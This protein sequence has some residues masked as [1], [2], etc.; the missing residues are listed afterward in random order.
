M[1][2]SNNSSTKR[3][4]KP[5][6][7]FRFA[8]VISII[9]IGFNLAACQ[10]EVGTGAPTSVPGATEN[11]TD[12]DT[13]TA[14]S[15]D[16]PTQPPVPDDTDTIETKWSSSG[17]SN[18]FVVT[19]E[20]KN[21]TCARCH[22]PENWIPT[23]EDMPESCS[24]CKFEIDPPPPY[25]SETD[26]ANIECNVCHKVKRKEVQPEYVWLEIAPIEE[27][28][29]VA[30]TTELCDK[31]HLAGDIQNHNSVIVEGDHPGYHCTDCHDAH[32]NTASCSASG[33]HEN[34]FETAV[35]IVGHDDNH[36]A[37]SCVACHDA[38]GYAIAYIED[39][40]IWTTVIS[41]ETGGTEGVRV[42]TSHNIVKAAHCDRCHYPGNPWELSDSVIA[43]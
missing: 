42:I 32:D 13:P 6:K 12:H 24:A 17:H 20:G 41:Q 26:W 15:E 37:I 43:E 28:A 36:A 9:L 34:I 22:S 5:L 30:T 16:Q 25:T 27:Y 29:D 39:L 38:E 7:I 33:C 35:G 4:L 31:C 11:Q 8:L 1:P 40:N 2:Q 14:P 10:S 23:V 18:T 21:S 19:D 3:F